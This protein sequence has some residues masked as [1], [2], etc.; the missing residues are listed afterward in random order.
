MVGRVCGRVIYRDGDV[1]ASSARRVG[2]GRPGDSE[3]KAGLSEDRLV[4]FH[5]LF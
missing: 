4:L 3:K 5:Q 2:E 1:T